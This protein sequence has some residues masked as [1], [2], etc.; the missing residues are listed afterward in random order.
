M[1]KSSHKANSTLWIIKISLPL[2]TCGLNSVLETHR[3]NQHLHFCFNC[4]IFRYFRQPVVTGCDRLWVGSVRG[5]ALR[6]LEALLD[7]MEGARAL[8]HHQGGA[9]ASQS[10]NEPFALATRG[11]STGIH[12]RGPPDARP[13]WVVP[14][15]H[16]QRAH[17]DGVRSVCGGAGDS[18][19]PTTCGPGHAGGSHEDQSHVSRHC[20]GCP[21]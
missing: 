10:H 1:R 12:G 3:N 17:S 4:Y 6:V 8:S 21:E 18:S 11:R 9:G 15:L 20:V 14:V 7:T 16:G 13:P 19:V 5:L 2:E